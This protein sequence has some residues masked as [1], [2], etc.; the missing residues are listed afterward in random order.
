MSGRGGGGDIEVIGR[1]LIG[2]H[3]TWT[4]LPNFSGGDSLK[5][6]TCGY[7]LLVVWSG[8]GGGRVV[9]ETLAPGAQ[10]SEEIAP[11]P[12]RM[13]PRPGLLEPGDRRGDSPPVSLPSSAVPR[14]T[15]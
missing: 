14:A 1:N 4:V 8:A 11:P 15:N 10:V 2:T 5:S 13:P 7:K 6:A 12:A 9:E 3:P